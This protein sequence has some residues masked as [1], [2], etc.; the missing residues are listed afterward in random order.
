MNPPRSRKL[1]LASLS[2]V[3]IV[4]ILLIFIGIST[5]RNL[6]RDRG[7]VVGFLERQGMSIL[8]SLESCTRSELLASVWHARSLANLLRETAAGGEITHIFITDDQGRILHH[9]DPALRGTLAPWPPAHTPPVGVKTRIIEDGSGIRI[10]ELAKPFSPLDGGRDPG[11]PR[12]PRCREMLAS[13]AGGRPA[14]IVLG[15]RMTRFD[16]AR[17]TDLHHAFIMIGIVVSLGAAALFFIFV[18]QKYYRIEVDLRQN[19]D[20][21]RLVVASMANGLLSIDPQGWIISHNRLALDLLGIGETEVNTMNL[22]ER[23]DFHF[24]G[25]QGTLADCRSVI[26]REITHRRPSGETVPLALS[27]TPI[28][29]EKEQCRGAVIVLR[30]LSEI[31]W[32]EEKVRRSEKLAAIGELAAGVAHEIRNPLSSIRG[33]AQFLHHALRD[34]PAEQEYA[35]VM[36]R[37]LDR[38]NRVVTDLLT[39]SRPLA[40]ERTPTDLAELVDHTF[41]L[42]T[43]D[44]GAKGVEISAAIPDDLPRIPLDGNQLTHA[45]LNLMLNALQAVDQ[46]GRVSVGAE[47]EGAEKV[48]HLWVEDDGAGIPAEHRSKIFDPF[49]TTRRKGTGLG[50]AIVHKIVENHS[51]EIR[52]ESPVSGKNGGCRFTI[53]LPADGA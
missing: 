10:F 34:R 4:L 1:Y 42:V 23:L 17:T 46:G 53:R 12:C 27:V 30:D 18:I 16:E 45:L 52:M 3:V 7:R 28:P 20:Y 50:L 43:A 39:F 5:V 29:D 35:G 48:F 41:R 37:E 11:D 44:A 8:G 51:G 38:I 19:Q 2:I 40:V 9:S 22:R 36:I 21:T 14:A 49:F 31:K 26:E 32:L 47:Y 25:I 33:F 24:T 15:Q 6:H 13:H